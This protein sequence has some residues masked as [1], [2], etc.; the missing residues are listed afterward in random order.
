MPLVII[1]P[2]ETFP[3]GCTTKRKIPRVYHQM[4]FQVFVCAKLAITFAT[5][6]SEQA[7]FQFVSV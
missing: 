4:Y 5:L 2:V 7:V 1:F 6:V 3:A